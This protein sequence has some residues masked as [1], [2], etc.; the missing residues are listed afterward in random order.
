MGHDVR[1]YWCRSGDQWEKGVGI[2]WGTKVDLVELPIA[3]HLDDFPW[4]E[5]IPPKGGNLTPASAVLETWLG[6][7]DWA[8]KHEPGGLLTYT[9]HPQVIGRGHRMLMFE[10]LFD[11]IEKREDVKFVTLQEASD[12]WRSEQTGN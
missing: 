3:W 4:F 5:Y 6:D 1:P 7:L 2:S 11:E 10:A 9:M 12:R 8:R